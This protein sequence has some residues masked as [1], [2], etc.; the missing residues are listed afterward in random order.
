M[1][2]VPT[3]QPRV[4]ECEANSGEIAQLF[5]Q[6]REDNGLTQMELAARMAS[7]QSTVARWETGEHEMTISTLHRISAALGI[8]VKLSIGRQL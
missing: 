2:A 7:T 4:Y 3:D 5:R 8:C 6:V 1:G